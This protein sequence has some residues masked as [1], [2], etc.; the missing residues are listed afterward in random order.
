M[1]MSILFVALYLV[2]VVTVIVQDRSYKP[3]NSKTELAMIELEDLSN[4][5]VRPNDNEGLLP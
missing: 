2:Y 1:T 5:P 3:V 4:M